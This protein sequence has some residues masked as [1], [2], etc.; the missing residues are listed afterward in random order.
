MGCE[1]GK[2]AVWE[3]KQETRKGHAFYATVVNNVWVKNSPVHNSKN[4]LCT[5]LLKNKILS[6]IGWEKFVLVSRCT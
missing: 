3:N 1:N 6:K 4:K 2:W 5:W